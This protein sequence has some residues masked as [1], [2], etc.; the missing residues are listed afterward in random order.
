MTLNI[1]H[2]EIHPLAAELARLRKVTLTQAVLDAV[3][4]ELAREQQR[5]TRKSGA[6]E[7]LEIGRRCAAHIRRPVS[8]SSHAGMLYD[9]RGLPR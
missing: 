4:E 3:R 6:E 7:L 2:P 9:K 5:Q 1:K 8:S